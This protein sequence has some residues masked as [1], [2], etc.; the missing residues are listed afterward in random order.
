MV[1]Q[2]RFTIEYAPPSTI[3]VPAAPAPEETQTLFPFFTEL[4]SKNGIAAA[5]RRAVLQPTSRKTK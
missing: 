3:K 4:S 1:Q 5:R 2:R